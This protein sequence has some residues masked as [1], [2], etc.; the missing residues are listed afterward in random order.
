MPLIKPDSV[1]TAGAWPDFD[2][3][4]ESV[5]P[6]LKKNMGRFYPASGP[7]D[8]RNE[9]LLQWIQRRA[10]AG[11]WP[12]GLCAV[13]PPASECRVRHSCHQHVE[14]V[15]LTMV[16]YLG[17]SQDARLK[18]A[19]IEAIETFGLHLP[20]SGPLMGNTEMAY[21]LERS[22]AR[23]FGRQ[24]SFLLPTGWA[25]GFGAVSGVVRPGDYV[26]MD[27]LS[28][29]CLQQGAYASTPNVSTF[30]HLDNNHLESQ[31][32]GL[33]AKDPSAAI[34]IITEGLFSMD[35]DTPNLCEVV[36]LASGTGTLG[37]QGVMNDIDIVVGSFSKSFGTN[38][39][40][41]S[42]RTLS[43]Q[44]AQLCFAGP[45]T[46]TTCISPVQVAAAA[47]ALQIV[48]SPEGDVLR[49]TLRERVAHARAAAARRGLTVIGA[50]SPIVP[51]L[52]GREQH[53]RLA[54]LYS[55][56]RGLIA[57]CLEFPVVQRGA[58]RYRLSMSPRLSVQ[59]IDTAMDIVADSIAEAKRAVD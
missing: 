24:D 2:V 16:D 43:M 32:A 33:R 20:S 38:G 9:P 37:T 35:G 27:E 42:S 40:F 3:Q 47:A 56:Q 31:L 44:W 8:T 22:I 10:V 55:F 26:L 34:L 18:A 54:G 21:D 6:L 23:L 50:P 59:Q 17:L 36:A 14:G 41:I 19:A 46:F 39:G 13:E 4:D 45:Y 15:N 5:Q 29:Q 1:S 52:I 30:R 7:I 11:L 12:Y 28:H 58:A 25:A 53:S 48:T 51:V 49:A 57:T